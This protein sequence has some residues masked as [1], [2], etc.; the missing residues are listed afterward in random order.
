MPIISDHGM[1]GR[2]GADFFGQEASSFTDDLKMP[3]K[4]VLE[5]FI[6]FERFASAR[7]VSLNVT[8][9]VEDVLL[10]LAGFCIFQTANKLQAVNRR[11]TAFDE[12]KQELVITKTARV[13]GGYSALGRVR[14]NC[15][16]RP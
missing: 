2:V 11:S 10:R 4:P 5:K 13:R 6:C 12:Q 16:I 15:S 9:G 3:Y 14:G 1:S 8:D 7:G